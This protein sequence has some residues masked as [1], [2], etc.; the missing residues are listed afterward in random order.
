[1]VVNV[2]IVRRVCNG[3]RNRLFKHFIAN[4]VRL[5]AV[6]YNPLY[7]TGVL[8]PFSP[9]LGGVYA[10]EAVPPGDFVVDCKGYDAPRISAITLNS[11]MCLAESHKVCGVSSS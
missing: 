1:M 11:A 4:G 6:A 9:V 8:R 2:D 5:N 7:L 10:V 3:Y